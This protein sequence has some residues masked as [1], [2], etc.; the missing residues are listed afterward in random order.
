MSAES[1]PQDE[2]VAAQLGDDELDGVDGGCVNSPAT[3]IL[4]GLDA[5][6]LNE[7]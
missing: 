5:P 4:I 1:K 3:S 7:R 6:G 2:A